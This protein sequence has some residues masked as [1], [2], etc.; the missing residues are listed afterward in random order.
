MLRYSTTHHLFLVQ[1]KQHKLILDTNQQLRK[2]KFKIQNV[3]CTK[4]QLGLV[5]NVEIQQQ[6]E[7]SIKLYQ[8]IINN[9]LSGRTCCLL[10]AQIKMI[11]LFLILN[12]IIECYNYHNYENLLNSMKYQIIIKKVNFSIT[13]QIK[14]YILYIQ[15]NHNQHK[16]YNKRLHFQ[17]QFCRYWRLNLLFIRERII[18]YFLFK[19]Y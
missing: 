5:R 11:Q 14:Q 19:N 6:D 17:K 9:S 4:C 8:I 16:Q 1:L 15:I 10:I 2:L 13:L 12:Q 18:I 3:Q 7:Q